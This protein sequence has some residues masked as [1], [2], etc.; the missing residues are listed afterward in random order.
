MATTV[1]DI[2]TDFSD[3]DIYTDVLLADSI[4]ASVPITDVSCRSQSNPNKV[5]FESATPLSAPDKTTL[6]GVV[7]AYDPADGVYT[8]HDIDGKNVINV[9][10]VDGRDVSVDGAT[11]D[12]HVADV[13]NPHAVTHAQTTGQGTDDHHAQ[14]HTVVSH[15]DTTATGAQ[16]NTLVGGGDADSEHIHLNTFRKN[17]ANEFDPIVEN[18]SPTGDD[19]ILI[20][21]STLG[22]SKRKLKITNLPTGLDPNAV[23]DN[24]AGEIFVIT[25]K[26]TPV[27]ADLII[28]E[29]SAASNVK[30]RVQIGNLPGGADSDAIHDNVSAE[31]SAIT[32]KVTPVSAD[33]L[34][35]E[36]SADSNNKKRVQVGN[37]P[38][39]GADADAI[40]DNVAAEISAI[41]EKTTPV[42]ADLIIIE[43]S[44]ASNAKKRVQIGNLPGG[45][46]SSFPVYTF[47][48]LDLEG[49]LDS[50]SDWQIN[51]LAPISVDPDND[52][53]RV[54]LH[55]DSIV[56]GWGKK[57]RIPVGA[58]NMTV[59][60]KSRPFDAPSGSE[61]VIPD[62]WFR[63][64][65][66]GVATSIGAWAQGLSASS[67]DTITFLTTDT[68]YLRSSQTETLA[69]WGIAADEDW[70][71]AIYNNLTGTIVSAWCVEGVEVSFS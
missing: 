45:G 7:A 1:Y 27:S 34:V 65:A 30:K 61:T 41:A 43:D 20:E 71:F 56:Q 13:A 3:Q 55:D 33:L 57:I 40:H 47:L 60:I 12:A 68:A 4:A 17:V 26:T 37:L 8:D 35:I 53:I 16:L 23:H 67:M 64:E 28:I 15:S 48:A 39:G 6:D 49:T 70:R 46:G 25:E 18:V 24:V 66:Y 63:E 29:D 62:I 32:E 69:A 52:A 2:T 51:V 22:G 36:D 44:A 50:S 31:I 38:G 19:L 42:S 21:D 10:N 11:L 54:R 9:A 5:L 59:T 58:A 14:V